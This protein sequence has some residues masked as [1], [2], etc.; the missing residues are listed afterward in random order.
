MLTGN[1]LRVRVTSTHV[2]PQLVSPSSPKHTE[3][4]NQLLHL[5]QQ[6]LE[7]KQTRKEIED[8]I[9]EL[10]SLDVEHKIF[11]GLAKVLLDRADFAEPVL[12]VDDPP[13]ASQVRADVFSLSTQKGFFP[14]IVVPMSPIQNNIFLK[15]SQRSTVVVHRKSKSIYILICVAC[16]GS[17][18]SKVSRIR[19][20][21]F[22]A[23]ILHF[24]RRSFFEHV[25]WK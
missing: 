16:S 17:T 18:E 12:P 21:L 15:R 24:V 7:H 5:F 25:L 20:F 19:Y 9:S 10:S 1:L 23:T 14:S 11:K 2:R 8:W 3:R 4:A 22:T 6:A 13:K